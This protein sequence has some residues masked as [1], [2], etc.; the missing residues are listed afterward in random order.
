MKLDPFTRREALKSL[1]TTAAI[2]ASVLTMAKLGGATVGDDDTSA[3]YGKIKVGDTRFDIWAGFQQPIV[4]AARLS[5]NKMISSTTGKEFELGEGYKSTNRWDIVQRFLESKRSPV[6]AFAQDLIRGQT[7]M[8]EKFDIPAQAIESFVPMLTEDMMDLYKEWGP[9]G[10]LMAIP[11][12]HGVGS[13]TYGDQVPVREITKTGTERIRWQQKPNMGSVIANYVRGTPDSNIPEAEQKILVEQ[14]KKENIENIEA[15]KIKEQVIETG[16]P[17]RFGDK[18]FYLEKGTMK[19]KD[20]SETPQTRS[21]ASMESLRKG[22]LNELRYL[23]IPFN[24]NDTAVKN[25]D[26]L[27]DIM[28][29]KKSGKERKK[30]I[31][32]RFIL[33]RQSGNK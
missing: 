23:G 12:A 11:G 27:I 9:M 24:P 1:F 18:I 2:G 21:L 7:A 16:E 26:A 6:A 5:R 29:Y 31:M 19:T 13:Q 14:R 17:R 4:A 22:V 28:D 10:L 20:L 3:D 15:G 25:I 30:G 8:G 32:S 33:F